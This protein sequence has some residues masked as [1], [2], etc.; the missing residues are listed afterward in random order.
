MSELETVI[1]SI[2]V[3]RAGDASYA[4][5]ATTVSL[6]DEGGGCFINVSQNIES[7][8][9]QKISITEEEWPAIRDAIDN[10]VKIAEEQNGREDTER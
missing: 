9:Y 3:K 8:G 5:S 6:D 4:E 10:M 7:G 1:S 2:T